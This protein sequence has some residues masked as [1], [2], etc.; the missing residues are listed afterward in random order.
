MCP[1]AAP[2]GSGRWGRS[3]GALVL[4][5]EGGSADRLPAVEGESLGGGVQG[6]PALCPE[7]C[8]EVVSFTS[9]ENRRSTLLIT[10]AKL[11]PAG[12]AEGR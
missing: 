9:W 7:T 8:P 10:F 6:I 3:R 5:A 1:A 2:G 4:R 11:Q 12:A